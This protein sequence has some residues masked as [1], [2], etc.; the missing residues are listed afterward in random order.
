[1]IDEAGAAEEAVNYLIGKGHRRIGMISGSQRLWDGRLRMEG[2]CRALATHQIEY[3]PELIEE[4]DYYKHD[5]GQ[6]AMARLMSLSER[7]TAVF[8]ASDAFAVEALLYAHDLGLSIPQD[9]AIVGFDN[10]REAVRVRPKLTTV[11]KDVD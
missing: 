3:Q 2:Y 9:L 4:A 11:Q 7:P 5:V 10:T 1:M 6:L 8:A